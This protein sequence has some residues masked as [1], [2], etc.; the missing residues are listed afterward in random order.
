MRV[1][2]E[3]CVPNV[4]LKS[5][6]L[7][8]NLCVCI[9]ICSGFGGAVD[10]SSV[11]SHFVFIDFSPAVDFLFFYIFSLVYIYTYFLSYVL[12]IILLFQDVKKQLIANC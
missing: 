6:L 9:C 2:Y 1:E 5:T 7:I 11:A 8:K 12:S 10:F 4:L 3:Y